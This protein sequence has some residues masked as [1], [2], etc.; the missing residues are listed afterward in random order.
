[1][2]WRRT[3]RDCE[4]ATV[5]L[6]ADATS[7]V[8]LCLCWLRE[9]YFSQLLGSQAKCRLQRYQRFES[10]SSATRMPACAASMTSSQSQHA[11]PHQGTRH[12]GPGERR[13][14]GGRGRGGC[15]VKSDME[16]EKEKLWCYKICR[17]AED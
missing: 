5:Q 6:R 10:S 7:P 13:A 17:R 11:A 3:G 16:K 12:P 15:H 14:G 2:R 1:V 8:H 4:D 9:F